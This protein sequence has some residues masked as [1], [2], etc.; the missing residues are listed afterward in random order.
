MT[1]RVAIA[2]L[3]M[4]LSHPLNSSPAAQEPAARAA[5]AAKP[6]VTA[7]MID[8]TISRHLGDKLLSST[9][10]QLS[11]T[12]DN[13]S[14]LRMG[15]DVPVPSVTFAPAPKEDGKQASP[16]TSFSYRS[17]GTNID[18]NAGIA[19]DGQYRLTL[20]IEESSI[21][22]PE[23]VPPSTKTT[24]APAFRTFK[25]NNNIALRDGQSLDYTMATD[26]ISGEVYR[27]GVKLTVI[28]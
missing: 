5:A 15:G 9:P 12:P 8:V 3:L 17:I 6:T 24:G 11:V 10:Y 18:V 26:R 7:L 22:A 25:S 4:W 14:S 16:L 19:M 2:V 23:L 21:Y 13:R 28:K 20:T 1:T 27:V